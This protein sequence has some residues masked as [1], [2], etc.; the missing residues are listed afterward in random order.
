[1]CWSVLHIHPLSWYNMRIWFHYAEYLRLTQGI[2]VLIIPIVLSVPLRCQF[3]FNKSSFL[4][5]ITCK[6]S[7]ILECAY[8]SF[9]GSQLRGNQFHF[10]RVTRLS[11]NHKVFYWLPFDRWAIATSTGY[12]TSMKPPNNFDENHII[13]VIKVHIIADVNQVQ[14]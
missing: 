13:P 4:N 7:T 14:C 1:M 5:L 9:L 2:C 3:S 11:W 6:S 8:E 10:H 12:T